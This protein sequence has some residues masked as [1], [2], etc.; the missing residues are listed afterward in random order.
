MTKKTQTKKKS[1]TK[2]QDLVHKTTLTAK[3]LHTDCFSSLIL[4]YIYKTPTEKNNLSNML[5]MNQWNYMR[6]IHSPK[7]PEISKPNKKSTQFD[8]FHGM[9]LLH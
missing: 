9:R 8:L 2:I 4:K 7:L 3:P 5:H 1:T 6:D